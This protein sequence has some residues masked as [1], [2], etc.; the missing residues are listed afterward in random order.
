MKRPKTA[1]DRELDQALRKLRSAAVSLDRIAGDT[2]A[3]DSLRREAAVAVRA[4]VLNRLT[5][6]G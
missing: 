3:G 2:E 1:A 6:R 5:G 4:L